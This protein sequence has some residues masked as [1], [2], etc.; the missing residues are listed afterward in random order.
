MK[1]IYYKKNIDLSEPESRQLL[2]FG[3]SLIEKGFLRQ[4]SGDE[5]KVLIY[6]LTHLKEDNEIEIEL[7]LAAGALGLKIKNL[8]KIISNLAVTG[9]INRET[10]EGESF[11]NSYLNLKAV[12]EKKEESEQFTNVS[13]AGAGS[14]VRKQLINS[15]SASENE[16]AAALIS[17]LPPNNRNIHRREEIKSW[18]NDFEN[19]MLKEL[20]RRVD[21]WLKR[22][23]GSDHLQGAY[24]YLKAIIDNW[25]QEEITTY[26]KLQKQDKLHRETKELARAYGIRSFSSNT[27]QLKTFQSWLSGEQA[28]SKE[29]ALAAIREAVRRK[30]DGQPSLKY[31][32]DNFINPI[33]ELGISSLADFRRWLQKE[34]DQ[35]S[36]EPDQRDQNTSKN[37]NKKEDKNKAD[38]S[39]TKNSDENKDNY[40][41]KDFFIDFD[42]YKE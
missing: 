1:K 28:L 31:V 4:F 30:R 38:K 29:L 27:A 24:A 32:E 12:I 10:A 22:Q 37:K 18:L 14:E 11:F 40:K 36:S 23:G 35:K 34:M 13:T 5:T 42:K 26:E 8:R 20:V 39:K 21:K 15:N 33:K 9:I 16:I 6:L 7:P 25:Y 41:W 2:T 3:D 19:K 17:F